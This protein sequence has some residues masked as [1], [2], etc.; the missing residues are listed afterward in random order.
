MEQW[1]KNAVL[2][3]EMSAVLTYLYTDPTHKRTFSGTLFL[4]VSQTI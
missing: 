4:V 1:D 3:E 2:S